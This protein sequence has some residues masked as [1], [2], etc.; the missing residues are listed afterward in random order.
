MLKK[1]CVLKRVLT[2]MGL[3][4]V[5]FN[6]IFMAYDICF[7]KTMTLIFGALLYGKDSIR[8]ICS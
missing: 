5:N 3:E 8:S 1:V 4:I 2:V 7:F 6:H